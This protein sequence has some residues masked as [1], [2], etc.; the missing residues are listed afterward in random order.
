MKGM[1]G[2]SGTESWPAA[3]WVIF[4]GIVILVSAFG[5]Q[6]RGPVGCALTP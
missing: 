4:S 3:S 5:G 6:V 2:S 1:I